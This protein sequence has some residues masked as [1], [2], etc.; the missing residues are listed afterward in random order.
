MQKYSAHIPYDPKMSICEIIDN[1]K[2]SANPIWWLSL[3]CSH[4]VLANLLLLQYLLQ[5]LLHI[6]YIRTFPHCGIFKN[7]GQ[8]L[9]SPAQFAF[10]CDVW[11]GGEITFD[12]AMRDVQS[13]CEKSFHV[14]VTS[15]RHVISPWRSFCESVC[16]TGSPSLSHKFMLIHASGRLCVPSCKASF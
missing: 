1:K 8:F 11:C 4:S 2:Y 13:K 6:L 14:G 5:I 3:N 10:M 12:C 9:R 7:Q 15:M 16:Q